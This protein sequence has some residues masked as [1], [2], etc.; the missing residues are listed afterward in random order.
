MTRPRS[1]PGREDLLDCLFDILSCTH[2]S[3]GL[4]TL[5]EMLRNRGVRIVSNDPVAY[6]GCQVLTD[7][8]LVCTQNGL[9]RLAGED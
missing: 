9:V 7:S 4:T 8:R 6:L 5:C 2:R 3:I 1:V